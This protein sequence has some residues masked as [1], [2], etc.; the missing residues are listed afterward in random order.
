MFC[1]CD[2]IMI[3]SSVAIIVVI[4]RS[5]MCLIVMSTIIIA[6]GL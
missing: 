6:C 3:V 4:F 1:Y 2:S 5:K